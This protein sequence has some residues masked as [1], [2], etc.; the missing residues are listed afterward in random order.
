MFLEKQFY[1]STVRI[2]RKKD[3]ANEKWCVNFCYW[4]DV[5]YI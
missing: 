3:E 5:L 4:T 1:S 2:K